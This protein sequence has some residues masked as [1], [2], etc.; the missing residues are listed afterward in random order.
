VRAPAAFLLA[1]IALLA[2]GCGDD[3]KKSSKQLTDVAPRTAKANIVGGDAPIAEFAEKMA[4]DAMKYWSG[5]FAASK[6]DYVQPNLTVA[7]A[8]ATN[9]CGNDYLPD[10]AQ[11]V[12]ICS[13][14]GKGYL[15]L[16]APALDALRTSNGDGAA[17]F[18]VGVDVAFDVVDQL[19]GRPLAVAEPHPDAAFVSRT[20]CFTG[21]WIRH[22]SDQQ[23]LEEGDGA[24]V[25]AALPKFLGDGPTFIEDVNRGFSGGV[26]RCPS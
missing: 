22:L 15:F 23:I 6:I 9:P 8:P 11:A 21:S 17:A 18:A 2:S 10:G 5:V 4:I 16:G 19:S 26:G 7:T 3:E 14:D 13:K 12:Y 20:A 1:T 24:E 25:L